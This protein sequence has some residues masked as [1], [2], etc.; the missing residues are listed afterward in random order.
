MKEYERSLL[1]GLG[2]L[3]LGAVAISVL[4]EDKEIVVEGKEVPSDGNQ[5]PKVDQI[6]EGPF[7][8]WYTR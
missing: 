7:D 4:M 2:I 5:I 1:A 6:P 3:A 8:G